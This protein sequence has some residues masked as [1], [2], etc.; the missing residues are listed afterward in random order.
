MYV[1]GPLKVASFEIIQDANPSPAYLG[2]F[3]GDSTAIS[4]TYTVPKF[5]DGTRWLRLET[6]AKTLKLASGT[7]TVTVYDDEIQCDG[8]SSGFT[9]TLPSPATA[10][11]K[12]YRF[13][14]T[15]MTLANAVTI[16]ASGGGDVIKT[17]TGNVS[18]T[19]INT[20]G[21][22]LVLYSDGTDWRVLQRVIPYFATS[23]TPTGSWSTAV[24]YTG[25]WRRV[26]N[27]VELEIKMAVTGGVGTPGAL[28]INMPTGMTI[29]SAA[30]IDAE[31]GISPIPGIVA[32]RD[33]GTENYTGMIRY[34]ST[35]TIAIFR[36]DGDATVS[37]MSHTSPIAT[38]ASG[39]KVVVYATK[40]PI[41]GWNAA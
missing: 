9:C 13:Q 22:L 15:D 8:S 7:Y 31:A 39:D 18:S 20:K 4:N 37:A 6:S 33:A 28:T 29:D 38:P 35:S 34:N 24:T 3:Y 12:I 21:E 25:Q 32:I 19:T 5:H 11:R 23:F 16:A 26:G 36:D 40:I 30:M 17:A 41:S 14:R 1:Y 27:C 10:Y 2:R